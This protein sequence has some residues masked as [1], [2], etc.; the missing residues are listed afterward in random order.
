MVTGGCFVHILPFTPLHHFVLVVVLL[1][2]WCRR[3]TLPFESVTDGDIPFGTS[4]ESPEGQE[5]LEA[6]LAE[7]EE[8]ERL[9]KTDLDVLVQDKS[10]VTLCM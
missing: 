10:C 2:L 3:F 1:L 7:F 8:L 4:E 6:E 9:I 5:A